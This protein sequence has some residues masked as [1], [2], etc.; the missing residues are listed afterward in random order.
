M[1]NNGYPYALKV[2]SHRSDYAIVVDAA[3]GRFGVEDV[4]AVVDQGAVVVADRERPC[5][6]REQ[7]PGRQVDVRHTQPI[8]RC[9]RTAAAGD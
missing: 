2:S 6:G 7:V 1:R 4:P 5:T 8:E 9:G 3:V